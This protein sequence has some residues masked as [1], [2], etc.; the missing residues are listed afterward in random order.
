M[1]FFTDIFGVDDSG[2]AVESLRVLEGGVASS[3][4]L[5][6]GFDVDGNTRASS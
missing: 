4:F 1:A 3:G 5:Y 6:D 2:S